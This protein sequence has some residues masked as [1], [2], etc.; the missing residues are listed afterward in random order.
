MKIFVVILNWN[1]GKFI[2]DCLG[3]VKKLEIR[4]KRS[5]WLRHWKLETIVVDNASEDGS[6]ELVEKTG[7]KL[8]R[9]K[10]NLGFA[11]GN[12]VGIRYALKNG[13]D[14]VM[15]LNPDTLVDKNLLVNLIE[16]AEKEETIGILSPKIYF[17]PGYEYHHDHY[18][19]AERGKVI[20]YAGGNM[21]W[22]NVL[23]SHRGVDEVDRGQYDDTSETDFGTGCCLL[24]KKHVFQKVGFLDE[25]YFLYWEDNDYCQ[26]ARRAG[27]GIYYI[28]KA[29]L[30]HLNAGSSRSGSDT[31]D[32][33]ISR[34]R[35]LF[36]M[37]YSSVRAKLALI[38]ESMKLL[39]NGRR[40]QK[41]GIRDFYSGRFGKGTYV[42]K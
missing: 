13:A 15:L 19:E 40:F 33:F 31:Q 22:K 34:N 16:V 30:F 9:N 41:S 14:Y 28:H 7:V 12:N 5:L 2:L 27:F 17:A 37:K 18:Q 20:W 35:M 26:R 39:I 23:A 1:G 42:S 32:Y 38:K 25:K 29:F 10:E 8:I 24:V 4:N 3:S 6:I 36:G 21:D 11:E